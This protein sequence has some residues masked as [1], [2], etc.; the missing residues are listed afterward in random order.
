MA[1][2]WSSGI[3]FVLYRATETVKTLVKATQIQN[4][5]SY[6]VKRLSRPISKVDACPGMGIIDDGNPRN[7][8]KLMLRGSGRDEN[9]LRI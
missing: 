7:P 3:L 2:S 1:Y 8:R 5:E 9:I 6:R 4:R